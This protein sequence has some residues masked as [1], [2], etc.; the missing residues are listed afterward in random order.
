M[1][2]N[3]I[4]VLKKFFMKLSGQ[5]PEGN[6]LI[7]VINNGS[8]ALTDVSNN[9]NETNIFL[10]E[11][12]PNTV[13][14]PGG[15]SFYTITANK[16]ITEIFEA[17]QNGANI[18]GHYTE[19]NVSVHLNPYSINEDF[20][21]FQALPNETTIGN[22]TLISAELPLDENYPEYWNVTTHEDFLPSI[23]PISDNGK[24]LGI[25]NNAW[26]KIN[27]PLPSP[28][29]QDSG[30]AVVVDENGSYTLDEIGG[31]G[32]LFITGTLNTIPTSEQPNVDVAN[33]S[34][35]LTDITN[36][37]RRGDNVVFSL[38]FREYGNSYNYFLRPV[39]TRDDG[40]GYYLS[41]GEVK[42][43][44]FTGELYIRAGF[45]QCR[46]AGIFLTD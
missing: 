40:P 30:K 25:S 12:T 4:N 15:D 32:N 38:S 35:S 2:K 36:A 29:E 13:T 37:A 7:E 1:K 11:F 19:N 18:Q 26:T 17:F 16:G 46:V 5:E 42:G 33:V 9:S 6:N 39:Y 34:E 41:F 10:V 21:A 27:M 3:L 24:I 28:T 31:G 23:E 45:N 8:D 44:T 43:Q 20:I 22:V 14:T